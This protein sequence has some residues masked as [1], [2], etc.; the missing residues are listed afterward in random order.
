MSPIADSFGRYRLVHGDAVAE[1]AEVVRSPAS[2]AAGRHQ[3]AG[4]RGA[5]SNG[6]DS[7]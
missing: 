3:G 1:L 7:Y 4:M 2:D 5:G 6:P